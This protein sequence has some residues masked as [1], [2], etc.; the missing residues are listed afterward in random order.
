[1]TVSQFG[2]VDLLGTFYRVRP[3]FVLL[4]SSFCGVGRLHCLQ[5]IISTYSTMTAVQYVNRH[6]A[7]TVFSDLTRFVVITGQ[8]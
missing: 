7:V 3:A 2:S 6:S 8:N 5:L 4:T 1:L